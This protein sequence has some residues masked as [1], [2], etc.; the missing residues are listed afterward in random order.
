VKDPSWRTSLCWGSVA[1]FL[2]LPMVILAL[3]LTNKEFEDHIREYKFLSNFY[4]SITA[5]VFGLSGL[6]SFDK[7][8]EVKNGKKVPDDK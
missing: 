7:F 5:L 3:A 8:V 1:I 4:Q 6:R 2:T